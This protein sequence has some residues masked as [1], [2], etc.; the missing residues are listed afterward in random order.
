MIFVAS[1][2]GGPVEG[3]S[4]EPGERGEMA[5]RAGVI[6][7][8]VFGG[9]HASKY[10]ASAAADFLGVFDLD[11]D[12]SKALTSRHGGDV[13]LSIIDLISSVDVLTIA[14]PAASHVEIAEVALRRG[15]HCLIEKPLALKGSDAD[16]LVSLARDNN[17]VLQV[18]HQ[19]RFVAD[20]V[21]LLDNQPLNAIDSVRFARHGQASP[22]GRCEDV[23][24]VFDLM[25]HDID[26][27]VAMGLGDAISI[28][29]EGDQHTV[30]ATLNS[31]NG[32]T[33]HFDCSRRA[34]AQHRALHASGEASE[35]SLDFCERRA[36]ASD[37]VALVSG[38]SPEKRERALA[39][40]L[41]FGVT[42]FLESVANGDAEL[43]SAA[44]AALAVSIAEKIEAKIGAASV[45]RISSAA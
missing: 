22:T 39:D 1:G 16:R 12:R 6:G 9:H 42:T 19:E 11:C 29:A 23:S 10:S 26:L 24:V 2:S 45:R 8:G 37:G 3:L 15:V 28:E 17:L 32:V 4:D 25:I 43:R 14:T 38:F 30:E 31:A 35:F 27:A 20:A 41:G 13:F 40:P 44:D 33:V 34:D 5:L 36:A 21:G 18:G 7:A